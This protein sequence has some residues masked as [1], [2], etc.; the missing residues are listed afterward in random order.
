MAEG[1]EQDVALTASARKR[2]RVSFAEDVE[3][4]VFEP[5]PAEQGRWAYVC[6]GEGEGHTRRV[7]HRRCVSKR[8]P[9]A[10]RPNKKQTN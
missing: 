7:C 2:A 6:W 8:A 5:H 3:V 1:S 4:K 9:A 10:A